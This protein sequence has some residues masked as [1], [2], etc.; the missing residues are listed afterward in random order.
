MAEN[1][2][3]M[4]SRAKIWRMLLKTIG[5]VLL[6]IAV[7]LVWFDQSR[8]FY[9]LSDDKCVTVWKR[10]GNK[11]YVV[12]GKY[13]GVS[14]PSKSYVKTININSI[15]IVWQDINSLL[16]LSK[17]EVKIF[18]KSTSSLSIELYDDKKN[19]NDSMYTFFHNGYRKYNAE[20]EYIGI[21]IKENYAWNNKGEKIGE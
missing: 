18:N 16:V 20:A 12:P 7:F 1:D 5:I 4:A 17:D 3:P 8:R 2:K 21:N 10:L 19:H 11:C 15:D 6:L 13:Y 9:C 14:K